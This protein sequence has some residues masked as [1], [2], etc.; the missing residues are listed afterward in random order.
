MLV[1]LPLLLLGGVLLAAAYVIQGG[2]F[3]S[4]DVGTVEAVGALA[5]WSA[6]AC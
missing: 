2:P 1:G 6:A 3:E 5:C 4:D